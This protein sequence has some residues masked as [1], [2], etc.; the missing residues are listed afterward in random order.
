MADYRETIHVKGEELVEEV[1]RLVHE[2]NVRHIVVK[3]EG[4]TV[5]EIPVNIGV[6]GAVLAPALAAIAAVGAVLTHCTLDVVRTD[7]LDEPLVAVTPPAPPVA[8]AA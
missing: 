6:I 3:H 8:P 5:L 2:G 1:K 4:N 7:T